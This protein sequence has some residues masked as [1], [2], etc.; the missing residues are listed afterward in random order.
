MQDVKNEPET[1]EKQDEAFQ[2]TQPD[3]SDK[4]NGGV[5]KKEKLRLLRSATI[6]INEE[7]HPL[8]IKVDE[9]WEEYKV[10]H[11]QKLKGKDA[12][13]YITKYCKD[14]LGLAKIDDHPEVLEDLWHDIDQ[15]EKGMV[16]RDDMFNHLKYARDIEMPTPLVVATSP[17]I[18]KPKGEE[19][20][21][22]PLPVKRE[23]SFKGQ[24]SLNVSKESITHNASNDAPFADI[25]HEEEKRIDERWKKKMHRASTIMINEDDHPCWDKVDE[26]WKEYGLTNE[27]SLNAE[28]AK[29]YVKKY[30]MQELGM[31]TKAMESSAKLL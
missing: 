6:Q 11:S 25:D 18:A 4:E 27:Q 19:V 29:D 23:E 9:I 13:A 24:A 12:K 20:K 14:E 2:D 5:D 7:E 1:V 15:A 30:A 16:S 17:G 26:I 10:K 22:I 3:K 31:T 28:Q 21:M 8:W